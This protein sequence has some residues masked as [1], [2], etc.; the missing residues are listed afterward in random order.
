[1]RRTHSAA[2]KKAAS[3]FAIWT[4]VLVITFPLFWMITTA[5]KPRVEVL[6]IPPT[7]LPQ[8]PTFTHFSD[9]L[10]RTPFPTYFLN[11][12][13][14]AGGTTIIVLVVGTLGAY[15]LVRFQ[16]PGREWLARV[17]LFTYLLPHVV[18][19]IPLYLMVAKLGIINSL[20]SLV[21]TYTAFALP[22]GLWL[23]RSFM[24][25]IPGDLESAALIDGASRMGAFFDVILP[26]ALP[27]ILSTALFTF[28]V[29]WNEYL[30]A[31][32]LIS[33]DVNKTLPVGVI[34]LASTGFEVDWSMLMA[35]SVLMS[36]PLVVLFAGLQ[37]H[38]TRG[39]GTGGNKG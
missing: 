28:I 14:V 5:L 24:S 21:L 25:A 27:G 8:D 13:I 30:F 23:L 26:L 6:R 1:M 11:S 7:I 4:V 37:K 32:V 29:A 19:V 3:S 15:S 10:L 12:V 20:F 22:F 36:V 2:L 16:Y 18:I 34:S 31:L 33:S 38:L 9:L 17:V 39:F 35:A